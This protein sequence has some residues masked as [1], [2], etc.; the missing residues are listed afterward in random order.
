MADAAQHLEAEA[1]FS[2]VT[3]KPITQSAELTGEPFKMTA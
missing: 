2:I 1:V 3:G